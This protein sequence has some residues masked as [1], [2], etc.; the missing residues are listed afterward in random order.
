[1]L[2]DVAI[3]DRLGSTSSSSTT[4]SSQPTLGDQTLG[5]YRQCRG[6]DERGK[7]RGGRVEVTTAH[8]VLT[9]EA[10]PNRRYSTPSPGTSAA[11][12]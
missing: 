1:M 6:N 2:L 5:G 12:K 11:A 10:G 3:C 7:L 9:D 8:D 4:S